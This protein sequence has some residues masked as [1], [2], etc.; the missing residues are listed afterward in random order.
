MIFVKNFL[1][2]NSL[3]NPNQVK[4]AIKLLENTQVDDLEKELLIVLKTINNTVLKPLIEGLDERLC[5]QEEV[6]V[7]VEVE[8][9]E[10]EEDREVLSLVVDNNISRIAT[11][12]EGNGFG[13]INQTIKDELIYLSEEY[14]VEWILE[15]FK[16]SVIANKRNR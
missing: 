16:V 6:E 5:K 8:V 4:S 3:E 12:Y 1:K 13:T 9:K 7:E 11:A 2:Y 10:E 15:A 14:S